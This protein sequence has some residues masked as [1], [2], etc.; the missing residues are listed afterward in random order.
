MKKLL[1]SFV[2][3]FTCVLTAGAGVMAWNDVLSEAK[4]KNPDLKKAAETLKQ[5]RLSYYSSYSGFLPQLSANASGGQSQSDS[6]GF[7]RSYS[8]GL[9]GSISLF[10]GF[11]DLASVRSQDANLKMS[12]ASYSRTYADTVYNLKSAFINLL[13]AQESAVLLENILQKRTQN[14]ELVQL[15]YNSGTQDKGSLL[16][17]EADKVSAEFNLEKARRNL[18]LSSLQLAKAI[19]RDDFDMITATGAFTYDSSLLGTDVSGFAEKTP[20]YKIAFYSLEKSKAEELS[21]RSGLYPSLNLS[22]STSKTGPEWAPDKDSWN[23]GLNLSYSFFPG[24]RN[25]YNAKISKSGRIAAEDNLI[26]VRQQLET[27]VSE[28]FNSFLDAAGVVG[29]SEKYVKAYEE[30]SSIITTQYINGLQTYYNWYNV[31]NSYINSLTSL[32]NAKQNAALRE[33]AFK[34]IIGLGE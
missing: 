8:Y 3:L 24:G 16:N 1:L 32:L 7:N 14:Y 21:G 6:S 25:I 26:S 29:V 2:L 20:E 23:L 31:E 18:K 12:E 17:V 33:A 19:G 13:G 28:A 22:G 34:K 5:A 30:Q 4:Q 15:Q 11:S 9:S 10:S 27:S